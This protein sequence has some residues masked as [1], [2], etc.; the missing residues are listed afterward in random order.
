L[1]RIISLRASCRA[2]LRPPDPLHALPEL[3]SREADLLLRGREARAPRVSGFLEK[4]LALPE[5][6]RELVEKDGREIRGEQDSLHLP[7]DSRELVGRRGLLPVKLV[8]AIEQPGDAPQ[9]AVHPRARIGWP[10]VGGLGTEHRGGAVALELAPAPDQEA[11]RQRDAEDLPPQLAAVIVHGSG[12]RDLLLDGKRL[13]P[14]DLAKIGP[15][16]LES[17]VRVDPLL[18]ARAFGGEG[19][20]QPRCLVNHDPLLGFSGSRLGF[21][22]GLENLFLSEGDLLARWAEGESRSPGKSAPK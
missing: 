16:C 20:S 1:R 6:P 22:R 8:A 3:L 14:A 12:Q 18:P 7:V 11:R 9:G 17:V 2:D 15:E 10:P 4:G 21:P 19:A 13:E 5:R